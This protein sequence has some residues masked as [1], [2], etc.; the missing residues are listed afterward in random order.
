MTLLKPLAD[1]RGARRKVSDLVAKTIHAKR[2]DR[3]LSEN[4]YNRIDILVINVEEHELVVLN[5]AVRPLK[6][7]PN[8]P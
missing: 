1:C 5:L 7:F 8:W 4:N 2:L 3:I 6:L